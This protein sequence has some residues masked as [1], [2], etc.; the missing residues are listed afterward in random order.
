MVIWCVHDGEYKAQIRKTGLYPIMNGPLAD[1]VRRDTGV[2]DCRRMGMV[3]SGINPATRTT[4]CTQSLEALMAAVRSLACA[5][6]GGQTPC[7]EKESTY[8]R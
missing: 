7:R 4:L 8:T 1:R 6:T 3:S 5:E 2:Q